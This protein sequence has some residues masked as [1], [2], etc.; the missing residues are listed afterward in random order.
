M[1][2]PSSTGVIVH[3]GVS[4]FAIASRAAAVWLEPYRFR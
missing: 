4:A 2:V 1:V 3:P